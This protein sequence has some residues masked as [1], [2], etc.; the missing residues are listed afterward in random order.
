MALK[1]ISANPAESVAKKASSI[2]VV[3]VRGQFIEKFVALRNQV[4]EAEAQMAEI[5]PR[6]KDLG[7]NEIF[8]DNVRAKT[9]EVSSVKLEDDSGTQV[10]VT[11]SNA[12]PK[13]NAD[14]AVELLENVVKVK[15]VNDYLL[16]T[17]V[18]KFDS[19]VFV[20]NGEF[21]QTAYDAFFNAIANVASQLGVNNPLSTEIVVTPKPDFH[22]RRFRE[23]GTVEAQSAL[24]TVMP[25]KVSIVAGK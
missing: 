17:R 7:V 2:R 23:F 25:T 8:T 18:A 11:V 22:D 24:H 21:N 4:D 16:Q 13:F 3:K 19:K 12:Y 5:E 6:I 14:Q 15:D 9:A 20:K 10:R 1:T